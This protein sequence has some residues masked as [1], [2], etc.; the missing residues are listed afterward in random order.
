MFKEIRTAISLDP[1]LR[2]VEKN[3]LLHY[4][5]QVERDLIKAEEE[6]KRK[7]IPL[8]PGMVF[9]VHYGLS[10]ILLHINIHEMKLFVVDRIGMVNRLNDDIYKPSQTI[11]DVPYKYVGYAENSRIVTDRITPYGA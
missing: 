3:S 4:L 11:K 2:G 6:E 1:D 5:T 8:R 9:D 10:A 7:A